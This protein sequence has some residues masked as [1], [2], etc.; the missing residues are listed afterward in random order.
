VDLLRDVSPEAFFARE[1]ELPEPTRNRARHVITEDRRTLAAA[2]AMR[3]GDA[4]RFGELMV[5]SHESLRDDFEVTNDA[6]NIMVAVALD[7][8]GCLGAR[9]TGAG[10][11]GCAVALVE[12]AA[13]ESFAGAV[14]RTYQDRT[15]L[16]PFVYVTPATDGACRILS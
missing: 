6:L 15:G 9:M 4:K 14:A 10:F 7:R 11:G 1:G 12:E 3:A 5:A 13:A 2:E 8:D 16:E